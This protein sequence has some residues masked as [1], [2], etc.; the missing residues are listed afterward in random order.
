VEK[1]KV[2]ETARYQNVS[3]LEGKFIFL[4]L[5]EKKRRTGHVR[6]ETP[7]TEERGRKAK[8]RFKEIQPDNSKEANEGKASGEHSS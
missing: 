2:R 5:R 4:Y 3:G 6:E 7:T 8:D 1:K